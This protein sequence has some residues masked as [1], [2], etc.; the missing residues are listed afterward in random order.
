M[1]ALIYFWKD[2]AVFSTTENELSRGSAFSFIL[3]CPCVDT[4]YE[5]DV[6]DQRYG[7][8]D[9]RGPQPWVPIPWDELPGEFKMYLLL[10]GVS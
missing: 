1:N 2:G 7:M 6:A 8:F 5:C 9:K 3:G 10:L 4:R